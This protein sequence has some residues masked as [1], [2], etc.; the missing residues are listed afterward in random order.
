MPD[1]WIPP[2]RQL[3]HL[4]I[5][6]KFKQWTDGRPLNRLDDL[7]ACAIAI[8]KKHRSLRH[9]MLQTRAWH[10]SRNEETIIL[11][12]MKTKELMSIELFVAGEDGDNHG[13]A[14]AP[15]LR[16]GNRY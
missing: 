13:W 8:A 4:R 16:D 15:A 2:L 9:I 14:S 11:E 3:T 6:L 7:A 12:E 5:H 1:D 10:I